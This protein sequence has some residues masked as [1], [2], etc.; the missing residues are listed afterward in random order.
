MRVNL[1]Q[2]AI[3]LALIAAPGLV[4]AQA[5]ITRDPVQPLQLTPDQRATI[6]RTIVPQGRGRSPIVRERIVIE[7][8]APT[9]RERVVTRPA[10]PYGYSYDADAY[11]Y[12]APAAPSPRVVVTPDAYG[13]YAYVGA[14][15]PS[16]VRLSPFPRTVVTDVP[17]LRSYRYVTYGN[18]VLVVDPSTNMVMGELNE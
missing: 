10:Q 15:V 11:A 6:Y 1:R 17:A 9:V 4:H 13:D 7:P 3:A 18:R 5:V 14:R 2:S 16:E 8:V 12:A